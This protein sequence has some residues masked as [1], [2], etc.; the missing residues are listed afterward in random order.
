MKKQNPIYLFSTIMSLGVAGFVLFLLVTSFG[1]SLFI[2]AIVFFLIIVIFFMFMANK[3]ATYSFENRYQRLKECE[4]CKVIIPKES[5]FCPQCGT[6]LKET[7]TCDYCGHSNKI[8]S[9][10][11][12]ECNGLIG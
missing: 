1:I 6:N 11:C 10:V 2:V 5:E 3:L 4:S 8:G 7:I 9:V 12:E